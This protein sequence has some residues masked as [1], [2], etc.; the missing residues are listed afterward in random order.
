[1]N[2][3]TGRQELDALLDELEERLPTFVAI[4]GGFD[5]RTFST[6][7]DGIIAS[8]PSEES[9]HVRGR[10]D[11]MLG[12]MGFIPSDNEGKGCA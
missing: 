7:A 1:M 11:C 2:A 12:S 10:I 4:E 9:E 8:A 5:F 6:I 3:P